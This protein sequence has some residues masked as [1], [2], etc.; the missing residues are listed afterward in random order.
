[1]CIE[2]PFVRILQND[3][4]SCRDYYVMIHSTVS[5]ARISLFRRKKNKEEEKGNKGQLSSFRK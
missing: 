5:E 2:I 1:M 3:Q 4:L